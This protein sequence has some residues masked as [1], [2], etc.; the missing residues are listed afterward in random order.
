[1]ENPIRMDDLGGKKKPIFGNTHML[2]SRTVA[3]NVGNHRVFPINKRDSIKV[4]GEL[5]HHR[6]TFL[7]SP[8]HDVQGSLSSLLYS[9]LDT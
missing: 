4:L 9:L 1:M 8:H 6:D 7:L 3:G 2:V 5:Q